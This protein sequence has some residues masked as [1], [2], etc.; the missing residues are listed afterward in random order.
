M[1]FV[2]RLDA[3]SPDA[4]TPLVVLGQAKC[5]APTSSISPDEVARVVARLRR[6]WIGIFV[7][8]GVFSKQAQV[9][10]IDDE[11]PVVLVPG[12]LLVQEVLQLAELAYSGDVQALLDNSSDSYGDEV[13]HRRPEEILSQA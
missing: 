10:V 7:T 2:G 3:G 8:T 11:Y 6:G 9:E 1:D 5:V 4:N 13:T 12:G